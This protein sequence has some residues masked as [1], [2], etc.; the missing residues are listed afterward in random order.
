MDSL[1]D[2]EMYSNYFMIGS[3]ALPGLMLGVKLFGTV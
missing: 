1:T 3:A 2:S